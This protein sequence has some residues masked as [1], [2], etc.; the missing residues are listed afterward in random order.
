MGSG[1][2]SEEAQGF[3]GQSIACAF[4][5][6][7][8]FHYHARRPRGRCSNRRKGPQRHAQQR[9]SS[10]YYFIIIII[11][12]THIKLPISSCTPP[13]S[14]YI[15]TSSPSSSEPRDPPIDTAT[16]SP[17]AFVSHMSTFPLVGSAL[18]VYEQRKASS[19][20]VKSVFLILNFH[21]NVK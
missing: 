6:V 20:V 13:T 3:R 10:V 15:S 4:K 18:R 8:S 16:A 14:S 21:L 1:R 17:P 9:L 19:R 7:C 5:L 2:G 12:H 11:Q